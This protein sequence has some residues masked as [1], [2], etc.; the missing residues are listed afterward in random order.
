MSVASGR[1]NLD[2]RILDQG[3]NEQVFLRIGVTLKIL[4]K[5]NN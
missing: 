1:Q 3:N 2:V 5:L 4:T